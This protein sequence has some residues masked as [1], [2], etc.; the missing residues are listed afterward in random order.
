[1]NKEQVLSRVYAY[2]KKRTEPKKFVPTVDDV[3]V[4]GT[5]FSAMDI[6]ALVDTALDGWVT[7][8]KKADL[9]AKKLAKFTGIPRVTLCNSGSSANLLAVTA[10]V[11]LYGTP[12]NSLIVTS[13]LAFPT[14]VAPIIQNGM[15]PYFVD[16]D[17]STL[18]PSTN[19]LR[20]LANNPK[21]GG[22][23][24]AHTLGFPY[25][26]KEVV[27]AFGE[28]GKWIISDCCFP[29][30]TIIKTMRGNIEIQNVVA[31]DFV[32][33][34]DGYKKVTSAGKTGNKEIISRFEIFATPDHPIITKKGVKS[35]D[36]L[37]ASDIIYTWNEKR[38]CIEERSII[39]TQILNY[40]IR[41]FTFGEG[42]TEKSL[43]SIGKCGLMSLVKFLKTLLFI[44]KT[45]IL[46]II[47]YPT[48]NFLRVETTSGY[49]SQTRCWKRL[50]IISNW[51][52]LGLLGGMVARQDLNFIETSEN[53]L[54]RI[55]RHTQRPVKNVESLM[56]RLFLLGQDFVLGNVKSAV[57]TIKVPVYN[58]CVSDKHEFFVGGILVHN[59]DALGSTID[60]VHV[61]TYADA[62]TLSFFPA[63]HIS[64]GEGGAV[65]CRHAKLH[66]LLHQYSNWGRSCNCSPG[67]NN[68]CGKRFGHEYKNLPAGFDHK[69]V[70]DKIG[71]NLKITDLQ[72]ALGS[73]QMDRAQ[74]IVLARKRNFAYLKY[75]L[76]QIPL[77]ENYFQTVFTPIGMS[78]SPFGFPVIIKDEKIHRL[79]II[80]F[81]EDRKIRTRPIFAGNI[82]RH[83]MMEH[84]NYMTDGTLVGCDYI[85][86]NSFWIGCH[87]ELVKDQLDYVVQS[88]EEFLRA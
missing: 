24:L 84:I 35:L 28:A 74:E 52:E 48:L 65:L 14:T 88:F 75:K 60:G 77:F 7:E 47:L 4:S 56:K 63:H 79:E 39:A 42:Q 16:V 21:V 18:N 2:V 53:S 41:E 10:L 86:E 40:V 46:S 6:T 9:F 8:G 59:C 1:V 26:E 25:D 23:I 51:L 87:T 38:S 33:T 36:T 11:D 27:K 82:T 32:F 55:E 43:L 85:M 80:K 3:P 61:G 58:L 83:P 37:S 72:A 49:I 54:G 5:V 50:W 70:F 81:L 15:I 30:G 20:E 76:H 22:I 71:Y 66:T 68:K 78:P 17:I 69:Y 73:S 29:G 57:D 64:S 19:K 67:E 45:V 31:G 34:R 12:K 44:I 62:A 13:A